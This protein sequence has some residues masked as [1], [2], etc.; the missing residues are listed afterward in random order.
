MQNPLYPSSFPQHILDRESSR[1]WG[2]QSE[3]SGPKTQ[4]L[5]NLSSPN[6]VIATAPKW[7][8]GYGDQSHH[9]FCPAEN[10]STASNSL[11]DIATRA[12]SR[13]H[14]AFRRLG[15]ADPLLHPP[16]VHPPCIQ[17]ITTVCRLLE[18]QGDVNT[19]RDTHFRLGSLAPWP[20][21]RCWRW[22]RMRL[23]DLFLGTSPD[24]NAVI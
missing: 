12:T 10:R 3:K 1:L 18:P 21:A 5:V 6:L 19:V 9:P 15:N 24:L 23:I 16:P 2:H 22:V 20:L 14:I 7:S 4:Q 13:F 17:C 11:V 8:R